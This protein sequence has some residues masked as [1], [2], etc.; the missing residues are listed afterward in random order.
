MKKVFLFAALAAVAVAACTKPQ[1]VTP[2]GSVLED[3][4]KV[5]YAKG[6]VIE[7]IYY[8]SSPVEGK[9]SSDDDQ[10]IKLTNTSSETS[11]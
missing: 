9:D 3:G 7:E 2:E 8:T 6:L 10:H 4:T 1:F 11:I 5:Q